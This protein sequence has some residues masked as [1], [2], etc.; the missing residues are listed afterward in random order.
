MKQEGL[1]RSRY[2][3]GTYP[4][5]IKDFRA[6]CILFSLRSLEWLQRCPQSF[7]GPNDNEL[8][9]VAEEHPRNAGSVTA[10]AV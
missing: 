2:Y 8:K 1:I 4:P 9:N 3:G 10:L 5:W 6:Q 7:T